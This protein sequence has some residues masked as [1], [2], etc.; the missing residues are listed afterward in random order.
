MRQS[1][2]D[3]PREAAPGSQEV[4]WLRRDDLG[5]LLDP[6]TYLVSFFVFLAGRAESAGVEASTSF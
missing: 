1:R 5:L 3:S 2:F 6:F 4:D